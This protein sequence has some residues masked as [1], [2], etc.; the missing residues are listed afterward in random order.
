M[1]PIGK[2]LEHPGTP[3]IMNVLDRKINFGTQE[4]NARKSN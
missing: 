4:N 1:F 2:F 3:K